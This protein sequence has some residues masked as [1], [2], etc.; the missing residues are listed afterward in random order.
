MFKAVKTI[1][2]ELGRSIFVG[3]KLRNNLRVLTC[4]ALFT[5]VLGLILV[6]MDIILGEKMLF[7]AFATLFG[8]AGCA[9]YAAIRKNRTAACAFPMAFCA[10]MFTIYVFTGFMQGTAI[11]WSLL[12]PIGIS[13]FVG[14]KYGLILSIYHSLLYVAVFY[15][16]LRARVAAYYSEAIMLRFPILF[17]SVSAFTFIAMVQYHHMALCDMDYTERL[18][19]EVE[20]QTRVATERADKLE[21]M[22]AEMVETLARTIDAK[23][24]YTNGHSFRVMRYSA[25]LAEELGW[26]TREVEML[27]W[28][29]L[30]HDIGKIGV[31]DVVLNK[32]S[33]LTDEEYKIIRSHTTTG[34]LILSGM[35]ELS[36]IASVAVHHH[37]RFDGCGY[38]DGLSGTGIPA[39]ARV[40]AIADTYDAMS[41]DRIYRKA[42]P[43]DV[44]LSEMESQRGKQFDPEY[45][46]VFLKMLRD[47]AFDSAT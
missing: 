45:L 21:R 4:A 43:P 22:S 38:P 12:M 13:Y 15:T 39:H 35:E 23:D 24:K 41:S 25:E 27:R 16:P 7:P 5:A 28:E 9:Y 20:K 29:S 10:I 17:I 33:R 44:I 37:E 3:E 14:V 47:G 31:P 2:K 30:L 36:G 1:W 11:F 34:G 32:P 8:G 46:D 42:L 18:N 40:V 26:D 19:A 6:V